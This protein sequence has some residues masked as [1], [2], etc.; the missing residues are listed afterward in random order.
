MNRDELHLA[1]R[2]RADMVGSPF[3][4]DDEIDTW[5]DA[6]VA[7]LHDL[8]VAQYG[9][10]Y[11]S[12]TTWLQVLQ[13]QDQQLG[14]PTS[15][16]DMS[17]GRFD[18]PDYN[19]P[20]TCFALPSDFARLVRC[21][22]MVGT[23]TRDAVA[24]GPSSS[25]YSF[26]LPEN[27]CMV[28]TDRRAYPMHHIDTV[29]QMIDMA[30]QDWTQTRVGYRLRRGNGRTLIGP[31]HTTGGGAPI[32]EWAYHNG[33]VIDFL[34][35]PSGSYAIQ[36]TYSPKP[37]LLPDHPFPEYLIFDCAASCLEKQRSDSSVLRALQE[38]VKARIE[39][40]GQTPDAANPPKMVDVYG[41]NRIGPDRFL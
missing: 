15:F 38:R 29:G 41:S 11:W 34:P 7:D 35:I 25:S 2:Q 27:W 39:R 40:E 14:W 3:V 9:A 24:V 31:T 28:V 23:V 13:Q 37:S 12:K 16:V 20:E 32:Y 1:I 19:A 21:Q 6:S 5:I 26:E 17:R 4:T 10:E 22:F 8:L 18:G 33:T 30:P 36:V